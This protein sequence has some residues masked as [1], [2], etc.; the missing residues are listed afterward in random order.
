MESSR[1][2]RMERWSEN[3]RR[4][5]ENHFT[6]W[7]VAWPAARNGLRNAPMCFSTIFYVI[8]NPLSFRI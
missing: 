3:G 6:R 4:R 8:R 1:S 7:R 2:A 5:N